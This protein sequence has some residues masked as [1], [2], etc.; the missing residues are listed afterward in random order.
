MPAERRR[1][2]L[3]FVGAMDRDEN[4]DAVLYFYQRIFPRVKT[5]CPQAEFWAVGASP[6]T[7]VVRLNRDPSV[8]VSGYV[9]N[10]RDPYAACDVFVAPMQ[11][12]GGI[13]NKIIDAMGA[14]RPVVTTSLGNEGLAATPGVAVCVADEPGLFAEQTTALLQ[15]DIFWSQI[16]EAGRRYVQST[17]NWDANVA[18]LEAFYTDLVRARARKGGE[19]RNRSS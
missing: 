2:R 4:C 9:K 11:L 18:R 8:T 15:Q 13:F 5:S 6:Q 7:R 1:G 10:L 17:Y 19:P 3:L 14:G 16:A 12:P